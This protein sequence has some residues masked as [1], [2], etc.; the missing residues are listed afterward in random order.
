MTAVDTVRGD[1]VAEAAPHDNDALHAGVQRAA[2]S[3][4]R[5][6]V[7]P[8]LRLQALRLLLVAVVIG[9]WQFVSAKEIIP[10][11]EL[12][13]PSEMYASF[14]DLLTTGALFHNILVTLE[15]AAIGYTLG[16]V[17]GCT[18]GFIL[19]VVPAFRKL[20]EPFIAMGNACPRFAIAPLF[21][22][23]FGIGPSSKVALVFVI[24]VFIALINTIQG[25]KSVDNDIVTISRLLG[26]SR[27]DILRKVMLPSTIPWIIASMRLAI[28]YSLGGAVVGELFS[29]NSG[30]GYLIGAGS[31]SFDLGLIFAGVF[32][33]MI[34]AWFA[35]GAARWLERRILRWQ[36]DVVIK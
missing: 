21:L 1:A 23:W 32:L 8:W 16:I 19:A 27:Y 20:I 26:A 15:E 7:A 5:E 14:S 33:I 29:G 12:P 36:S 17:V 25:T 13:S 22:V 11:Y 6:T 31:A 4:F 35:D 28:A 30:L 10:R 9:I 24:V 34:L 18:V 3:Q 2:T